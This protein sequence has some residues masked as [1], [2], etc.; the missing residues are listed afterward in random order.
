MNALF[1]NRQT[2]RTLDSSH[3]RK[4]KL[5]YVISETTNPN[6]SSN[7]HHQPR[8]IAFAKKYMVNWVTT[9]KIWKTNTYLAQHMLWY[10]PKS[11]FWF[12]VFHTAPLCLCCVGPLN[13]VK[14][15]PGLGPTSVT[16]WGGVVCHGVTYTD[17]GNKPFA[18]YWWYWVM[19]SQPTQRNKG[20]IR[21][22]KGN[23]W[24]TSLDHKALFLSGV[25]QGE[26]TSHNTVD[27]G[28]PV[29][30][31]GCIKPCEEWDKLP[32]STGEFNRISS[33]NRIVMLLCL[34]F[35]HS[36]NGQLT[37]IL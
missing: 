14:R 16:A 4:L 5:F 10:V 34:Y 18:V 28:N 7:W 23:Q 27:G 17:L 35:L 37:T 25:R 33:I 2:G 26:L 22:F 30:H 6:I 24:L 8:R 9:S 1:F 31:L 13:D 29:D 12:F 3:F 36:Q 15:V 21:P 20:L 32:T 11:G 19:A